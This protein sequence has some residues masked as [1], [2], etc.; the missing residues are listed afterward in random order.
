M[1]LKKLN[2]QLFAEE[3]GE[4]QEVAD[5]ETNTEGADG[6]QSNGEDGVDDGAADQ[7]IE[8]PVKQPIQRDFEKDSAYARMR[9]EA[10]ELRKQNEL[11]TKTYENFGFKGTPEDM[12]D[13]AMAHYLDKPVDEIRNARL[14]K[15]QEANLEAELNYYKEQE[16]TRLMDEDL[17]K[18]QKVDPTV[19]SLTELDPRYFKFIEN[20]L[21]GES[22][23]AA[24][25]QLQSKEKRTPPA[26]VGKI[27]SSDKQIKD[28]YSKEEVDKLTD[29]DL[30]D[31]KIWQRV[32]NSMTKW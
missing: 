27:N 5:P 28:Y 13:Q 20:G 1:F 21:D 17:K 19:K 22:A 6:E 25:K 29:A 2:L 30:D 9:R 7:H 4:T 14:A 11:L 15:Q 26:E 12:A 18:I 32:R 10:E 24:V 8:E 31:P 3:S 16:I 23:F